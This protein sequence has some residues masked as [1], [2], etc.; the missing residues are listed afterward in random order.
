MLIIQW[1]MLAPR[2]TVLGDAHMEY[3]IKNMQILICLIRRQKPPT[4]GEQC[5]LFPSFPLWEMGNTGSHFDA[6]HIFRV[7]TGRKKWQDPL[8]SWGFPLGSEV[9][10][11]QRTEEPNMV[12]AR[13]LTFP[14]LTMN[15]YNLQSAGKEKA[16][17]YC[18]H[19]KFKFLSKCPR[20]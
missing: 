15:G 17:I 5:S 13:S 3:Y 20:L 11:R 19:P 14:C 6:S 12:R 18:G 10:R 16:R 7:S 8:M 1:L 2:K 9:S 4:H